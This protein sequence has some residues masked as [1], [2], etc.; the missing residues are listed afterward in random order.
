MRN[1]TEFI[2]ETFVS[3]RIL[4]DTDALDALISRPFRERLK[5]LWWIIE[6]KNAISTHQS[7]NFV[8][9]LWGNG[10]LK[11]PQKTIKMM[12]KVV[13]EKILLDFMDGI[14]TIHRVIGDTKNSYPL[15]EYL[16]VSFVVGKEF[17]V[18]FWPFW[19]VAHTPQREWARRLLLLYNESSEKMD[20]PLEKANK[21]DVIL[22]VGRYFSDILEAGSFSIL[23]QIIRKEI[24][25]ENIETDV[26]RYY[27]PSLLCNPNNLETEWLRTLE[28]K[29][30]E[31]VFE[32]VSK[33]LS[34]KTSDVEKYI[35]WKE[36]NTSGAIT[37]QFK[38]L[39]AKWKKIGLGD[40]FIGSSGTN[41]YLR[42]P[43]YKS[44]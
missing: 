32:K 6:V 24:E 9:L 43:W 30:C 15:Y 22:D 40:S 10:D 26:Y 38:R 7:E 33:G 27:K 25:W 14:G 20:S 35:Y 16:G 39:R 1:L 2:R 41:V 13:K 3:N 44:H 31:Y 18:F 19:W 8:N 42:L 17:D 12:Q 36:R 29:I 11:S 21:Q 5:E 34:I 37:T 28:D 23:R 4:W